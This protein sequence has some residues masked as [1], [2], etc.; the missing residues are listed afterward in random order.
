[1][2]RVYLAGPMSGRPA[3]NRRGFEE[4]AY[5]ARMRGFEP[6]NPHEV[7]PSHDGPCPLGP[8]MV[9][10]GQEHPYGCWLKAALRLMLTCEAVLMLPLWHMSTGATLEHQ[11]AQA[12]SMPI[13]YL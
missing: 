6:I 2:I 3:F 11:V 9:Y 8:T 7:D 13:D 5:A 1:M 10:R 4:A 12:C